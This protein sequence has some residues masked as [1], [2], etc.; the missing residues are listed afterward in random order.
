[1]KSEILSEKPRIELYQGDCLEIMKQ[2]PDKSIEKKKE[3]LL[4]ATDYRLKGT[5]DFIKG[6]N[7]AL[8]DIANLFGDD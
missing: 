5:P 7:L 8:Q 2:I 3:L 1:M 4:M 6:Y